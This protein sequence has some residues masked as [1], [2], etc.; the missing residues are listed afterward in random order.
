MTFTFL[1]NRKSVT[2]HAPSTFNLTISIDS[3]P[4]SN[5]SLFHKTTNLRTIS[6]ATGQHIFTKQIKSCLDE[7]EYTLKA[8]NEVGSDTDH[9]I[10]NVTCKL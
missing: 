9:V 10:V 3:F 7:G 5:V 4:P 6:N 1:E 2:A 8:V